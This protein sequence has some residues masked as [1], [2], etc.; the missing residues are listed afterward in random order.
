MKNK[1]F[2]SVLE[3]VAAMPEINFRAATPADA[4]AIARLHA[5][6]WARHYRGVYS[7]AYLE[8]DVFEDRRNVWAERFGHADEGSYTVVA[9]SDGEV[10]GFAHTVLDSDPGWGAL[11]DNLHVYYQRKRQGVGRRLMAETALILRQRRPASGMYLWVLKQNTDAQAFYSAMGGTVVEE[12]LGGPFPGGGHAPI[13]RVSW[14]EPGV[15]AG[16]VDL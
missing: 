9:D 10:V 5:D 16:P 13:L 15:L 1:A 4:A 12:R 2:D 7:D 11:L 8:G 3:T 14:P 6:S